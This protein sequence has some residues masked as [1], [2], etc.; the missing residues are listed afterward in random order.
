MY[1][2]LYAVIGL[3]LFQILYP[4]LLI[5]FFKKK[6]FHIDNENGTLSKREVRN[7]MGKREY[8]FALPISLAIFIINIVLFTYFVCTS[9]VKIT[10]DEPEIFAISLIVLLILFAPLMSGLSVSYFK[11]RENILGRTIKFGKYDVTWPR[12]GL[13]IDLEKIKKRK[14]LIRETNKSDG[15]SAYYCLIFFNFFILI[16]ILLLY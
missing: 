8:I 9:Q 3:S 7:K 6:W 16:P 14:W 4:I 1:S 12:T 15:M 10:L 11:V 13:R 5:T 2:Y